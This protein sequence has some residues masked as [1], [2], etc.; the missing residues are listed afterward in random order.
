MHRKDVKLPV[1]FYIFHV[2][3]YRLATITFSNKS[4]ATTTTENSKMCVKT[5]SEFD[6][7]VAKGMV[8]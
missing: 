5:D 4:A 3:I 1:L 2:F 6:P 7:N 8:G